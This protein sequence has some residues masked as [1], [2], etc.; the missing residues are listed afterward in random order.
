M[1]T[2]ANVAINTPAHAKP[3]PAFFCM[4]HSMNTHAA[5]A[6]KNAS[7]EYF[8]QNISP[9]SAPQ[10]AAS[11]SVTHLPRTPLLK[12]TY[13]PKANAARKYSSASPPPHQNARQVNVTSASGNTAHTDVR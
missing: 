10:T 1:L 11:A 12:N 2:A 8:T 9:E 3:L 13:T 4:Q 5:S 6:R 7:M